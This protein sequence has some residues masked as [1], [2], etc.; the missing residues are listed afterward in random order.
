ML[1]NTGDSYDLDLMVSDLRGR[2]QL[3]HINVC[4]I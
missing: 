3:S 2:L 4:Y 1:A